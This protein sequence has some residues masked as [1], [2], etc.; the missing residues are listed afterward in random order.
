MEPTLT[1]II[2]VLSDTH[3]TLH[4]RVMDIFGGAGVQRILHAGDVGGYEIIE[5]LEKLASVVAVRGNIDTHGRAAELPG[6]VR[7]MIEGVDIYM[8]HVGGKPNVWLPRLPQPLPHIA[9]CGHSHTPLLRREGGVLFLN[10]GSASTKQ[11]FKL[12][13]ACALL[14]LSNGAS[15]AEIIEL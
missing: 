8:T 1:T 5:E 7:L 13:L 9:I 15:E 12:P 14:K 6:K 10:P 4:P 3:G 2:G 11:R